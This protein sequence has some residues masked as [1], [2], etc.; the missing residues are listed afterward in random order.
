[1][2]IRDYNSADFGRICELGK[3]IDPIPPP[4]YF[5]SILPD[6]RTWVVEEDGKIVGFLIST[7]KYWKEKKK[8]LPYVNSIAI[9]PAYRRRGIATQLLNHFEKYYKG[10]YIF[11]LYVRMDN[12]SAQKLYNKLGYEV[13]EVLK[14]FYGVD[15]DGLFMVKSIYSVRN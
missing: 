8:A 11:G 15:K 12:K 1:M 2:L 6:S 13:I 10:F 14:K 5:R 4:L 3:E 9:D 7:L